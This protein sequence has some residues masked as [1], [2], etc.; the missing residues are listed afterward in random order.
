MTREELALLW[1]ASFAG[2]MVGFVAM[3]NYRLFGTS[4]TPPT[5]DTAA[6]DYLRWRRK[7]LWLAWSE[8]AALPL[9][10]SAATGAAYAWHLPPPLVVLGSMAAGVAG[11]AFTLHAAQT[12]V[13][14]RLGIGTPPP[15]GAAK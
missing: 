6:P 3:I 1:G 11:F 15:G 13:K 7:R 9:Y 8:F 4:D 14:L 2:A 5:E 12:F 10:A